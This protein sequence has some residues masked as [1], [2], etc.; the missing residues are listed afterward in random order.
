MLPLHQMQESG[1]STRRD[2]N[3]TSFHHADV[4]LT[5]NVSSEADGRVCFCSGDNAEAIRQI[6]PYDMTDAFTPCLEANEQSLCYFPDVSGEPISQLY[7][8]NKR[9]AHSRLVG[10]ILVAII[11]LCNWN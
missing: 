5:V 8:H 7:H 2:C 1:V 11:H 4:H 6:L 9:D 10:K 3:F